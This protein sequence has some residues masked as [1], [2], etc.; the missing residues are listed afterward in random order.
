[1]HMRFLRATRRGAFIGLV[2]LGALAPAA[3]QPQ[4]HCTRETLNVTGTRVTVSYCVLSAARSPDGRETIANVQETYS[5]ARGS[6]GQTAPLSFLTGDDPSRVIEDVSLARLGMTGTL[7]LTL[8]MRAQ[9][10]VVEAAILTPGAI[11]VK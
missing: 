5:S 10:V 3:A 8:I 11:V 7:H 4:S 6:F 9:R 2:W 1:M